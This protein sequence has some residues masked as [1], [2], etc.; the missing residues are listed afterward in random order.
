MMYRTLLMIAV[1]ATL[2]ACATKN[3]ARCVVTPHNLVECDAAS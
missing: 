3:E 2:A 1:I